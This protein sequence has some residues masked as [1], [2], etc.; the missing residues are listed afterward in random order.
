MYERYYGLQE[1][2]FDL[3]PNPRF[4]C[5]TAQ[6]RE[7]LAHL[8]YGLAGRPGITVIVGEAGTGK[9]TLVR[10]AL[11]AADGSSIIVHLSNPTLTRAEFYEY[12]A[13]GF[14]FTADAGR[15]KIQ[16]LR[17]VEQHLDDTSKPRLALVVDE[18]QSVPYE[19]L[20][21]IRLLTNAESATGRSIAVA[22]V[23]Q[24]EL[25]R[26]L[27]EARL[28]Q[29]KQRVVLRCELTPLSLKDTAAYI[30]ARV[31][32]AGGEATR[33]FTRDA[34]IAI[35]QHSRGIP[36]VISVV[37]DNAL[38]NGFA[39]DQQPVGAAIVGEVCR[40]LALPF[41]EPPV[42]PAVTPVPPAAPGPVPQPVAVAARAPMFA[43]TGR[44]RFSFF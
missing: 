39:A 3:S 24:P 41:D 13:G 25:G 9:T 18:A 38:V 22:L 23:G 34:V 40:T 21:E 5:F 43:S 30:S 32:T 1:R 26:R 35:H 10:K 29:L 28:R 8:E 36:R 42:K 12:L 2:P 11:Q 6:H 17:E 7:A 31:K 14:R 44:R 20:E 27:D 19:L 16:F 15:S 33:L 37:C 4:L